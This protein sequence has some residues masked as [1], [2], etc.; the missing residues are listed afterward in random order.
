MSRLV[1]GQTG[2]IKLQEQVDENIPPEN[3][4]PL[5][6]CTGLQNKMKAAQETPQVWSVPETPNQP[7][8]NESPKLQKLQCRCVNPV[9]QSREGTQAAALSPSCQPS[10]SE[11][12]SALQLTDSHIY[13]S[14]SLPNPYLRKHHP[15]A[16]QLTAIMAMK[17]ARIPL[18]QVNVLFSF[19]H[20]RETPNL[21]LN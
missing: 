11:Q 10:P 7:K 12:P 8:H 17:T 18:W 20:T 5:A 19:C 3:A 4:L 15:S 13:F 2:S 1:E 14:V 9:W 6:A 21:H 16:S